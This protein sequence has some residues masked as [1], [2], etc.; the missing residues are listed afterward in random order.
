MTKSDDLI[1]SHL[2]TEMVPKEGMRYYVV[3]RDQKRLRMRNRLEN[4]TGDVSTYASVLTSGVPKPSP[5]EPRGHSRSSYGK[6]WYVLHQTY[7]QWDV[8]HM[9][10]IL[11]LHMPTYVSEP[12]DPNA[13]AGSVRPTYVRCP[14]VL[15]VVL[16]GGGYRLHFPLLSLSLHTHTPLKIGGI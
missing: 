10:D 5:T 4:V 8:V 14:I 12:R 16:G 7:E 9:S 15:K 1:G 13:S 3:P 11:T 6:Q 2:F